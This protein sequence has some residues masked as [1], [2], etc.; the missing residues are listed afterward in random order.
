MTTMGV[1]RG[2]PRDTVELGRD[3]AAVRE[4]ALTL[5]PPL[6][7]YLAWAAD[8]SETVLGALPAAGLQWQYHLDLWALLVH[9]DT[10]PVVT[11]DC[12]TAW[13]EGD[14]STWSGVIQ[15]TPAEIGQAIAATYAERRAGLDPGSGQG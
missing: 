4:R 14:G 3:I 12:D 1:F 2:G 6:D 15:G 8:I 9:V 13:Y 7:D 10:D 5:A 11:F